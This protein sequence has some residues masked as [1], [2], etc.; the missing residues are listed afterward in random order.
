MKKRIVI[1]HRGREFELTEQEEK[2]I[3]LIE[4]LD[5]MDMGRL[6]LFANGQLSIRINEQWQD[7]EILGTSVR[8]EAGDGGD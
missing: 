7:N 8:C 2:V 1:D 6:I 4:R 5:T 3:R